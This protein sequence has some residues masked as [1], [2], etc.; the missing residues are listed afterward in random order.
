MIKNINITCMSYDIDDATRKEVFKKLGSLDKYMPRHAVKS[1]KIDLRL[2]DASKKRNH[3][4]EKYEAEIVLTIPGEIINA[5]GLSGTMLLAI[6]AAAAKTQSQ[7][8]DY[9][10]K[11]IAH[12]GRR[13]I[14]SR[15]KRSFKREL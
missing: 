11:N 8:R 5:S 7:L 13:G 3:S 6:D 2:I 9:K 14:L 4:D 10:Q 15:F 1:A 12:I